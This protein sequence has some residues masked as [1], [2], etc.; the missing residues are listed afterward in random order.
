VLGTHRD[1]LLHHLL[2]AP[3]DA[4][5]LELVQVCALGDL[6]PPCHQAARVLIM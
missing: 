1:L 3:L 2:R 5:V 4:N 6:L